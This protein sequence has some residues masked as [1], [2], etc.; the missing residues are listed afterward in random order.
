MNVNFKDTISFQRRFPMPGFTTHYL[1]GQ[2]TYQKLHP[3][4]LKQTIQ[5]YHTVFALG[6]QGPDIFFYFF[7]FF[8]WRGGIPGSL[9]HTTNT[10][11]FLGYLL[12]SPEI[13]D[14]PRQQKIAQTYVFGFIGHY[15]L[16]SICH[17]YV[18]GR[19]GY[20]S[21]EKGYLGRHI[22]LET[23]IDATL[24]WEYQQKLPSEFH[25][26]ECITLT[27]EQ[28]DIVSKAV[29]YAFKKAYPSLK[30]SPG[31]VK[32]SIHA[33]RQGCKLLYDSTGYKKILVRRIESV[34]PGYAM[35]SSLIPSDTILYHE[36]PLNLNH[37]PWSNPWDESLVSCQSFPELFE[38]A[39]QDYQRILN[40]IAYFFRRERT[41]EE[42]KAAL[43][44]MLK[45]LGDR[46]YHSG[47]AS[48]KM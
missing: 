34:C 2:Q 30:I 38:E 18:Y 13:F 28:E 6:L 14:S 35:L 16:D 29:S 31:I 26:A 3:S 23:D 41:A 48:E 33:I 17:P 42:K 24:L 19:T 36:D 4:E 32:S 27:K 40:D 1:F 12:K 37:H 45:H 10:Q 7:P 20:D 8:F 15:L 44:V 47:L 5:R 11:K 43:K 25:G 21:E 46:S 39:R 22:G 9:A